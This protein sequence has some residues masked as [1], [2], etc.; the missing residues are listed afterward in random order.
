MRC[1]RV[2]F[3]L[4]SSIILSA[5]AV[6][7]LADDAFDKLFSS[8]KYG[9]AIA[10]ADEKLSVADRSAEVWAKLGVAHE[11]QQLDEKALACFMVSIRLDQKNYEAHLGAA[12][13]YNKMKQAEKALELSKKAMEIK[14]TGEASWTYAQACIALNRVGEAKSALE[15]VAETDPSNMTAVRALGNV[16]YSE[17]NYTKAVQYLKK[18][19]TSKPDGET[20]L[21]L[22][23]AYKIMGNIDTAAIFYKEA[24]RDRKSAQPEATIELARIYVKKEKH[25]DAV[26][27][28]G[29][30]DQAKLTG[31]DL[32]DYAVSIEKIKGNKDKMVE[33][34]E[35]SIKKSG[36]S[37]GNEVLSSK[38]KIGRYRLEQKRYQD[39][40]DMLE[41]VRK[42]KGDAKVDPEILFLIAEAY[43]GLRQRQKAIPMLEA[44]IARDKKNVEAYAR[45]ADLYTKEKM[46][47]KAK[48]TYEKLLSLQP[49][50]PEVYMALGEYNLKAKK[51]DEAMKH[52]QKSF[53]L[54][55][56][57]AAAMG[58]M[59]SA[60]E[61]KKYD[62]AR[63]AAESALHKDNTLREPQVVLAKIYF[64]EKNYASSA[65]KLESLLKDDPKNLELLELL[66]K[67]YEKQEKKD[68]LSE[69]DRRIIDIDK[70]N[71]DARLRLAQF[72]QASGDIK[73]AKGMLDELIVLQPK[74]SAILKSLY[75]IAL[76]TDEKKEAAR[77]LGS[78]LKLVPS[79]AALQKA[80]GDLLYELNDK[81]GA[82]SAYRIAIKLNPSIKGLYKRYAELVMDRKSGG[83]AEQQEVINV[84][85]AAVKAGEADAE[86][87]ATL[88]TIYKNKGSFPLAIDMYQK[89]LQKDPKDVESLSSLAFC[90]EKAGKVS[91]A[92]ISYEQAAVL[93]TGS[94][95]EYKSLGDLYMKTGKKEQAVKAY[96]NFLEK[97]PEPA[98]AAL[99][100]N[101][102]YDRKRYGD[103]V[104]YF[105][106]V[107]GTPAYDATLM[108]RHADAA[109]QAGNITDAEE[110]YRTLTV[111]APKNPGPFKSLYEITLKAGR[112]KEAADY[113]EK[114]CALKPL[115]ASSLQKSGDLQY[116]LKNQAA[117]IAAYRNLL[118]ADPKA[119][120]FYKRYL[121]LV[122]TQGTPAEKVAVLNSAVEAGEAD[123]DAYIQLGTTY[124]NAKNYSKAL[125][126]FEK[127]SQLD[128][129]SI[130]ALKAIA[131]CQSRTGATAAAVLTYEQVIALD[132]K[133]DDEYRA[134][135]DLYAKQNKT[136]NAVNAYK[137]YLEKKKDDGIA[138]FVGN[139]ALKKSNYDEAIL[140][141][142]MVKGK[143]SQSPQF[144]L[145]YGEAC[146]K[147]KNDDKALEVY[148]KLSTITPDNADVFNTLFDILFRKNQKDEALVHLRKYV[149]LK[150]GDANA[151]KTLGDM[152]YSRNSKAEAIV[153]YRAAV[154]ANP[155]IKGLYKNFA[156]LVIESGKEDEIAQ[157]LS[158][159]VAAGEADVVMYKR[160][161]AIYLNQKKFA[162]AIPMFEKASQLEPQNVQLLSDLADAQAKSGN[163]SAALLTYEQV[164]ALNPKASDEYKALGDLYKAQKKS[165]L[166][167]RNYKKYLETKSDNTVSREVAV[168]SFSRKEYGEAVKYFDRLTG[169]DASSAEV[170]QT[171]A[172]AAQL[173]GDDAKAL[174]LYKK[175][176]VL[177]PSNAA[178]LEKLYKIAG[179]AGT[180][181]EV[182][183][184]LKK[185]T[186]LKPADAEAQ[187][188]LG[189][190]LYDKKDAAGSL[191]A[192]RAAFK[193][194]PKAKGFFKR[195]AELVMK[196]GTDDEVIAV[197]TAA[198][199]AGEADESMYL[200]LG[201][202]HTTRKNY[203]VAM[204]MYEKASQLNP[205]NT[206]TLEKLAK[207]QVAA[208]NISAATL[209]YEQ[210]IAMS[211][212]AEQEY[213]ELGDLYWKQNK[214][215][216]AL[217]NY[218]KYLGTAQDNAIA[219]LV[220][221]ELYDQKKYAEAVK[222]F[223][224]VVGAES[225]NPKHL[226]QYGQACVAAKD[227]FK[228]FQIFK[229]LSNVTPK[230]PVVF[231]T[232]SDL[233]Q[234]AGT[235][236]DVLNYL[237]AYTVLKPADAD[238]QKRLGDLLFERK[239]ESGALAAYR[240]ALKASP[241][242][243]GLYKN[244]AI[245]VMSNG[246]EAEKELA[247]NGA[248]A[249][250]EADSKMYATLGEIYQK[251]G[252]ID[253]AISV[254]EKA[255]QLDP[256]N[257]RLLSA[258]AQCQAKK[259][260][261]AE[262][263]GTYE[264]VLLMN[265]R[266]DLEL[267]ALGNLYLQ[268]KRDSL[269]MSSFK[270]Y[271]AKKP[272][273]AE[274]ALKV[275]ETA[276]RGKNYAD[277]VKYFGMVK[278]DAENSVSFI[279][280]YGDACYETK[281]NPRALVQY[282]KLA[283]LTPKD[284]D[285]YKKLYEI[286]LQS[287]AKADALTNLNIYA[288]YMPKDANAQ[289][290][291]GNMLFDQDR[292][293]EA[294]AAY[295]KAITADPKIK[296]IYKNYVS[297]V[298]ATPKAPDKMNALN[299]AIAAGEADAAV[300]KT[301]GEIYSG[302]KNYPKAIAMY[303]E[304]VKLDQ[305]N[306]SLYLDYADC[307]I[308]TGALEEASVNLE[309]ALQL[310]P[311]AT[312][313][314]KLL[315][316]LNMRQ[317]KT[318]E[319]VA[320]YRKYLDRTPGDFDIARIVADYAYEQKKYDEA[321]KY[322][323]M[324]KNNNTSTF[325]IAYGTSALQCKDYAS[326]ITIL[327]KVRMSKEAVSDRGTA[328]KSL[329]EAY[330][331][332]G[333]PRK[334]AEVLYDYVKL[335]G[336]KD[337]DAAYRIAAVY[338]AIDLK[339][340]LQMY[341]A[342]T[343]NYPKDHRNFLKLGLYLAKQKDSEKS[344]VAYLER[345]IALHDSNPEVLLK[346][347]E[348]YSRLNRSDDMLRVYRKFLEVD[349]KNAPAM[350]NI[351]EVLLSKNLIADAMIFL[352]M[353]NT[354]DE[355][356]PRYMTLL[357]RGYLLTGQQREGARLIEK[358]IKETKGNIDDDL[359]MTL[360][361]VY[362]ATQEY[363]KAT[364]EL[365]EIMKTN[366]SP[367]V[368][369]KYAETLIAAGETS[370]AL[371]IAEQIKASQPENIEAHMMIGKIKVAQ[372]KYNDAIETYKEVLYM[373]QNYAPA[374]CE[375]ANVYLLQ[376][377]LQWAQTF[378]DRALK[379]DP[380]NAM[381]YL[382]LA[383]LA[384]ANKDYASYSDYIEK[385]RKI[386]PQNREI[387]AEMR[388]GSH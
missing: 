43:D 162:Q 357:A 206:S 27:E 267:K 125:Q 330:E 241:S 157:V 111:K 22:A 183:L 337:P 95:R 64:Q 168:Y 104:K 226:M 134:L 158:G 309:K 238:A 275:G 77:Y 187:E 255:S 107:K 320:A 191:A 99:V 18:A 85:T 146:F 313:E 210:V 294:L 351:G 53:T 109:L 4:R 25:E 15:K 180:P 249:S 203:P 248:I 265:P 105:A 19:Y 167:I 62:I 72:S 364:A 200:R 217:S 135:G 98:I 243:K 317:K 11:E 235:K 262:A 115:D 36:A 318:A 124:M 212:K 384:K 260:A 321:Y 151:Q 292:K 82:L 252:L 45:L 270:R 325:L 264:Q 232:L 7:I 198:I 316:D 348:I 132:P 113:L 326:A 382:G 144:L 297:L 67:C 121:E 343:K 108:E 3:I 119:K 287:G 336:V 314:Y 6:P 24:S 236:D 92:I 268:Q 54:D 363:K 219:G 207:T 149:T 322:Y 281:D 147:A 220:G 345:S 51:Y 228:A 141:F 372:K 130:V 229:Q 324:I 29:K 368:M 86:I 242:I 74:N 361:D 169:Q 340:A 192:Y 234:R 381:I 118:K 26:E 365:K 257:D 5:L 79:D 148:R 182:L 103:A 94:V 39:A 185:Y 31:R 88:G 126:H 152:L 302:A 75:E 246:S 261:T 136:D 114:Y 211:P 93:N 140:Y 299:G 359:R 73:T 155:Q 164:T 376:G 335:P 271:L 369:I 216:Q 282:Q 106:M 175:L 186:S 177:Q 346:L 286:N 13:I 341:K 310:N 160:L 41:D 290:D 110:I 266:A 223:S 57:A 279:K 272:D 165:D 231:E 254:Y 91:D 218:K 2:D 34:L 305:K 251:K 315:G 202:I 366:T 350:A 259:G 283:K 347:G 230:D 173:A 377:K 10:Y 204:S 379:A 312:K 380:Q 253:K 374:L 46:A 166:S 101:F 68:K 205:K 304:A 388:S 195:Y 371:K 352:E 208:G 159:A 40:L 385:A 221:K 60:W 344:A 333:N 288:K 48:A 280:M 291:L 81:E 378:Y 356:N 276:F 247:L 14:P 214:T 193:A 145:A 123:A 306:A 289:K 323:S 50:S 129:K 139:A 240:A 90:Q 128:P 120:G 127:A 87:Y 17:K 358:V 112:K 284:P 184:Y 196:A 70:K 116:E 383:R 76:K 83:A 197:L 194:N 150:P 274:V 55:Q 311:T 269:A 256:K 58:M 298:L 142:D 387:Q 69:I 239:D 78:Y 338:E 179:K 332:S 367:Q 12:R 49:N 161:G 44:T 339:E 96:R 303:K 84:L 38:E 225:N 156:A 209:T 278:G 263:I 296:G 222:Y 56:K 181:D 59:I 375:R 373:D 30:A 331:K 28:F 37:S 163:I 354:E 329:A 362:I 172:E 47:D 153:A 138:I 224:M 319:A 215:D 227:E 117:A 137:K 80:S 355:N 21:D 131:E 97:T 65:G 273:D 1:L 52:F 386:A 122:S 295:R 174:T 233:A 32:Y 213:K 190:L 250:G 342:N 237:R 327:E 244:Y 334:A 61:L 360:A 33:L 20:A 245:L 16:F 170:L 176:S 23:N 308:K 66:A 102:E 353:A 89:A 300:F 285:V 178:V 35:A 42:S 258:L 143:E 63:D 154:K 307:L 277:A 199:S 370:D 9:E 301:L 71:V 8:G 171:H 188:Q 189:N 100:G 328:Y 201:S 133:A 349:S 293:A